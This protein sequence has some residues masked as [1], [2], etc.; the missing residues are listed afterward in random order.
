[1]APIAIDPPKDTIQVKKN[2]LNLPPASRSRLEKAGMNSLTAIHSLK[3]PFY[4]EDVRE[5]RSTYC[6]HPDASAQAD[7][8]KK[9]VFSAAKEVNNLT[10]HIGTEIVELQLKHLTDQQKEEFALLIAE[11]SVVFLRD[12]EISP[13]Q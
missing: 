7:P 11:R 13:Q 9:A 3:K 5:I 4:L 6:E 12:Q 1:M 10:P 8:A 2:T